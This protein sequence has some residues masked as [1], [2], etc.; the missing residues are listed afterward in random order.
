MPDHP[1]TP[2]RI[3][4]TLRQEAGFGCCICGFPFYDYHHII[5]YADDHHFRPDDMMV[6]CPNHH[7]KATNG[8]LD[9]S[10][11]RR[12]KAN[13]YNIMHGLAQGPLALRQ[14]TLAIGL[15]STQFVGDGTFIRVG[16]QPL[17]SL[18]LSGDGR[19]QVSVELNDRD[20]N[21]LALI[22]KNEWVTGDP[23]PWDLEY[24]G[25][26][27]LIRRQ[28]GE[29][30]LYVDAR[31]SLVSVRGSLWYKQQHF[32][33]TEAGIEFNGLDLQSGQPGIRGS[34]ISNLCLVGAGL[35]ATTEPPSL[36]I[37]VD[38]RFKQAMLVSWADVDERIQKGVEAWERL[39]GQTNA[40]AGKLLP[41]RP[42]SQMPLP[43]KRRKP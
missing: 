41:H 5:P 26:W 32:T 40:S 14:R 36:A 3:K 31:P 6:L 28:H 15:G 42:S 37:T 12:F 38:P 2:D 24:G 22:D 16:N 8:V 33:I 13:P 1:D 43:H 25:R 27:L 21:L 10:E 23:Y 39:S 20:G 7:R 4:R 19:L 18:S 34:G 30:S 35:L 17:L 9:E 29:I 11:Q